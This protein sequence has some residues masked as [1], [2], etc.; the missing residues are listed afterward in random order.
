MSTKQPGRKDIG[1]Q[2]QRIRSHPSNPSLPANQDQEALLTPPRPLKVKHV[3]KSTDGQNINSDK[4]QKWHLKARKIDSTFISSHVQRTVRDISDPYYKKKMYFIYN[5]WRVLTSQ[6]WPLW[7]SIFETSPASPSVPAP[8]GIPW[9]AGI[10]AF[11]K[12]LRDARLELICCFYPV[13]TCISQEQFILVNPL[14]WKPVQTQI[15]APSGTS[16]GTLTVQCWYDCALVLCPALKNQ[17]RTNLRSAQS[18]RTTDDGF[19]TYHN[20]GHNFLCPFLPT[21]V[22]RSIATLLPTCS[23]TPVPSLTVRA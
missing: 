23:F 15:S 19:Y 20:C 7:V 6:R 13:K 1:K 18:D 2:I 5:N 9:F 12:R 11:N 8:W 21:G 16:P 4:Q 3:T 17:L 10:A 22:L 14:N